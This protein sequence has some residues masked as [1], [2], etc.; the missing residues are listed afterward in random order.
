MKR[1][2]FI[3]LLEKNGWW[4]ARDRGPHTIYTNGQHFEAIPRHK[5]LKEIL[6][7]A[8]SKRRGLK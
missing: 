8:I 7:R 6:V 1:A 3:R 4:L 2:E 5:K